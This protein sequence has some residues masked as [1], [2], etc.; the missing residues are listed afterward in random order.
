MRILYFDASAGVSGDMFVGALVDLGASIDKIRNHIHSL[1]IEGIDIKAKR[2]KRY[3]LIGTKFDVLDSQ[4]GYHVDNCYSDP[5]LNSYFSNQKFNSNRIRH[6]NGIN[7][8]KSQP[9]RG[10]REIRKIIL[11]SEIPKPIVIDALSIFDLLGNAEA[12]VHGVHPDEIHFHEI[13]ALDAIADIVSAASAIHQLE[14]DEAWCSA[15][16]VGYGTVK[17]AHGILPVP[18]PATSELLKG[19]PTYS[20]GVRGEL[21]TPTGAALLRYFC[22]S[23]DPKMPM[24]ISAVGY[25]FGNKDFGIP[26]RLRTALAYV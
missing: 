8:T 19:L 23:F 14:F 12:K 26:N 25:G 7:T 5:E 11:N 18:A 13:G 20:N 22:R 9:H 21:T 2:T 10:L 24:T 16:H 4:T 6:C 15:I 3:G 1:R 17:C